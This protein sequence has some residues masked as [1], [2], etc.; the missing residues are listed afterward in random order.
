[1]AKRIW[2]LA[3]AAAFVASGA[4]AQMSGAQNNAFYNIPIA[5][6]RNETDAV[7]QLVL[8]GGQDIDSLDGT[9]GRTALD[10]AASFG[11]T[12][13][14]QFLLAHGAHVDARDKFGNTAL[15][16]AAQHG[17]VDAITVLIGAKAQ[18]DAQNRQ[19]MTPL[20]MAADQMQPRAVQL[21][22]QHGADPHKQD[23]TGRDA[24]GWAAGRGPVVQAL[25]AK[26]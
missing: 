12:G 9:G 26:R 15:H 1:M 2:L 23:F 24:F 8:E 14:V 13:L 11:N 22:L 18:V 20:M 4:A 5:A 17:T 10:Y 7:E 21:L 3:A 25:G 16:W 6:S 19:G